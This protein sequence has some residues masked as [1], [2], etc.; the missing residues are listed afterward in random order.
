MLY[1]G[2]PQAVTL[3]VLAAVDGCMHAFGAPT[4]IVDVAVQLIGLMLLIRLAVYMVRVSLGTRARLKGWGVPITRRD[5]GLPVAAPAGLG[6][7]GH[8]GARQHRHQRGQDAHLGLVGHEAARHGQP[9]RAARA[10][11]S[12]WLERRVLKLDALAPTMRIGIA[13]FMQAFLVGLVGA[14]RAECGRAST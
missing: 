4:S 9:V 10:V 2:A 12:R 13:K 3:V 1:I 7:D 11:G 5:L 14:G 6:R 8:R